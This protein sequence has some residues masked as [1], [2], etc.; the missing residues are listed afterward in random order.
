LI[1]HFGFN[2]QFRAVLLGSIRIYDLILLIQFGLKL[3]NQISL[4]T[5]LNKPF[6]IQILQL[7][8]NLKVLLFELLIL[9][10]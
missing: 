5:D 6:L 9:L 10:P 7:A 3:M 1:F 4:I 2:C 8:L